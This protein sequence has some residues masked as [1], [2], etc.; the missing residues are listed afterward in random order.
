MPSANEILRS[1]AVRHSIYL[2]RYS[3]NTVSKILKLLKKT[4]ANIVVQIQALDAKIFTSPLTIERLDVLLEQVRAISGEAF[5]KLQ[6]AL[7]A[8]LKDLA[9][10]ETAFQASNIQT[11]VAI[12]SME[13]VTP[14]MAEVY[15]A[16]MSRPFSG[17]LLKEWVADLEA[18]TF[19]RLRDVVRMGVLEGQTIDQIVQRVKGTRAMGYKDGILETSRR[20]AEALVRTA[21]SHAV[22]VARDKVYQANTNLIKGIQW[23]STLDGRTSPQCQS[24]DGKVFPISSGPR[25]PAHINCRSST[26]PVLKSW[27]ELGI[28]AKEFPE[29]TRASMDGQVAESETYQ[30]WLQK[31]PAAF[32]DD[33]LGPSRGKLFRDGGMQLDRFVDRNGASLTLDQ[34]RVKDAEAFKAA[35][36]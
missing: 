12:V 10:H 13:V 21:V 36:V 22:N 5:Y 32:Q 24:L 4:D 3:T 6:E 35:R 19:N 16:T 33:V 27:K 34:L 15:A 30:T 26:A 14:P 29:G 2:Q 8:D 20:G 9:L 7:E 18:S 23:I 1:D 11:P 25:P 28:G 31:Q 17:R